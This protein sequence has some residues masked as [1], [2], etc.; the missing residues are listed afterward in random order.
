M[1]QFQIC[2]YSMRLNRGLF[3][4]PYIKFSCSPWLPTPAVWACGTQPRNRPCPRCC[5]SKTENQVEG[6]K[7][8]LHCLWIKQVHKFFVR[9]LKWKGVC[10]TTWWLTGRV[11]LGLVLYGGRDDAPP[12][13]AHTPYWVVFPHSIYSFSKSIFSF[14]SPFLFLFLILFFFHRQTSFLFLVVFLFLDYSLPYIY[15]LPLLTS[16]PYSSPLSVHSLV[17]ILC[18]YF[19]VLIWPIFLYL[20]YFFSSHSSVFPRHSSF[21][22]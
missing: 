14:L 15:S 5:F 19:G 12:P 9:Y 8:R 2:D 16:Q 6:T 20:L 18:S 13:M 4:Y 22:L 17:Y 1:T 3:S 7:E 21:F 10:L 11:A